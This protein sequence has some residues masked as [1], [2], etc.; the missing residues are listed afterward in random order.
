MNRLKA[1]GWW[2]LGAMPYIIFSVIWSIILHNTSIG[3]IYTEK[4]SAAAG[5]FST[6]AMLFDPEVFIITLSFIGMMSLWK[7][8][9]IIARATFRETIGGKG[10]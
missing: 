3:Q 7:I 4:L 2:M 9:C 1:V 6:L 5:P 8:T 10:Q